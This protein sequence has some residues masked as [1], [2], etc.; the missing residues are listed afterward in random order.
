MIQRLLIIS[1]FTLMFSLFSFGQIT[2]LNLSGLTN[3]SPLVGVP[4]G[5][6]GFT[7]DATM[8]N[9]CAN[10]NPQVNANGNFSFRYGVDLT[11]EQ[12]ISI[13]LSGP[14]NMYITDN[15]LSGHGILEF[16]DSMTF[17]NNT[18][19]LVD[20]DSRIIWGPAG[21]PGLMS[22]ITPTNISAY[23]TWSLQTFTSTIRICGTRRY[24]ASYGNLKTPIR[25]GVETTTLPIEL[26]YFH[27]EEDF[28]NG[29]K[30][31]W[32]T[33]SERENDYFQVE[34]SS[35]L[36]NWKVIEQVTGAGTTTETQYYEIND[37][38]PLNGTSYYRLKQVDFNGDFIYSETK[39]LQMEF[40]EYA[41]VDVFPNPASKF[42]RVIGGS[43]EL[44]IVEVYD[45]M[46]RSLNQSV[47]IQMSG[48]SER[49]IDISNLPNGAYLVRTKSG[50]YPFHKVQ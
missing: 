18:Y 4:I 3:A 23:T 46:G 14:G 32:E 42:I 1:T 5:A 49:T 22:F 31:S 8:T 28:G 44:K 26:T 48:N 9:S 25:I 45:L 29:A 10:P 11:C 39:T 35:D 47:D 13:T 50:S 17:S 33:A 27:V 34:R 24:T 12:C 38:K 37:A 20:P 30:V 40:G 2:Y 41:K 7:F 15:Q 6:T 21:P 43:E 36:N 19:S 16:A